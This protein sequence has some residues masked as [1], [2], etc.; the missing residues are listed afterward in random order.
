MKSMERPSKS[1]QHHSL[2][3]WLVAGVGLLA[4]KNVLA[5]EYYVSPTGSDSNPGT[6]ASP[7]ASI[8]KANNS[9][10][11]G[12]TIWMRAGTYYS[13]TQIN[14]SKSG[15]S[16]TNRTKIWAYPGEV[17]LLDCSKYQTTTPG[18]NTPAILVT[19]SWMHLKGLEIANSKVGASGD[20]SYSTLQ[21]KGASNDTFE[22]LNLHHGFGAGLFI[23]DTKGGGGHLIL[24]CDSHDNYDQTGR[25]P[26]PSILK[27]P[28]AINS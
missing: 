16:D 13:T 28:A 22:L 23:D 6:Q 17:P 3:V 19:G 1:D 14:L 2:L 11:A 5:A 4:A 20:H 10:A 12:D 26:K 7:F 8:Q 15:T 9:A 25:H 18:A 24:N 21:T 27:G